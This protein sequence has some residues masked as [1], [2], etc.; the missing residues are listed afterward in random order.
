MLSAE[1]EAFIKEVEAMENSLIEY[2]KLKGISELG[3]EDSELSDLETSSSEDEDDLFDIYDYDDDGSSDS[4]E[5]YEAGGQQGSSLAVP[6][7]NQHWLLTQMEAV[8]LRTGSAMGSSD[9]YDNVLQML[10]SST[11]DLELQASLPDILGF[12][13]LDL[14]GE[15]IKYRQDIIRPPAAS[16]PTASRGFAVDGF[17]LL[18]PAQQKERLKQADFTH[19]TQQLGPKLIQ[20]ETHYP[21]VYKSHDA[22][23][24]LSFTGRKYAL[25]YGSIS[26]DFEVRLEAPD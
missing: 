20:P 6:H 19:K 9:L 4:E 15:L 23:N 14:I 25:P 1:A 26:Q 13:E 24:T 8:A 10:Q 5:L 16:A 18:T 22:G 17:N 2:N 7:Y 3:I 12:E 21:H 11:S